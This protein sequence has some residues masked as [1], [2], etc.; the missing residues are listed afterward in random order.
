M[1]EL[2]FNI[3]LI[4]LSSIFLGQALFLLL[5]ACLGTKISSGVRVERQRSQVSS[6]V[7]VLIPAHNEEAIIETTLKSL[8]EKPIDPRQIFVV[9][10]NCT[11]NTAAI[12]RNLGVSVTERTN[13][14]LRGKG[15]ALAHGLK[16]LAN[17]PPDFVLLIDADSFFEKGSIGALIEK[18]QGVHP[19]QSSYLIKAKEN[20]GLRNRT[21]TFIFRI[22]NLIRTRALVRLGCSSPIL[23]SGILLPWTIAASTDFSTSNVVEDTKIGLDLQISGKKVLFAEE[24]EVHSY[25][26]EEESAQATQAQRWEQGNLSLIL[27]YVPRVLAASFKKKD[28]AIA[29]SACHISIPPISLLVFMVFIATALSTLLFA[30][31]AS[32]AAL[33]I[34]TLSVLAIFLFLLISWS[35]EGKN[36]ISAKEVFF[37]LPLQVLKKI[38]FYLEVLKFKKIEWIRTDR[39]N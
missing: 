1:L 27:S 36:I 32:F 23:G 26:P 6:K 4:F 13:T 10:D 18:S 33:Y 37:Q 11:D 29:I 28:I 9:A 17:N 34:N 15:H 35:F 3:L 19:V 5:Q 14:S 21:A 39:D 30:L 24:C 12:A 20:S 8:L 31:T 16:Y 25:F 7:N 38:P 22:R 2:S